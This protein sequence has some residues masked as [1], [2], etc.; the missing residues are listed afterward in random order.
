MKIIRYTQ[1]VY[2]IFAAIFIYD[3]VSKL[4]AK[5]DGYPLSFVIAGVCVFMFFFRRTFMK[6]IEE[7][8]KNRR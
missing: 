1:Y 7:R 2:L 3:A 4:M 5:E 6:R 8:S